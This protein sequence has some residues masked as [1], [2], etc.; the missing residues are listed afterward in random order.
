MSKSTQRELN[1]IGTYVQA[2]MIGTAARAA[3]A[4]V[5]GQMRDS[6]KRTLLETYEAWPEMLAHP[7]FIV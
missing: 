4:L 1:N 5:R 6:V 3:S 7:D 2:G